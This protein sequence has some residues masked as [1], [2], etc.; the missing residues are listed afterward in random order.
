[1]FVRF[2]VFNGRKLTAADMA[3]ERRA[4]R[5]MALKRRTGSFA[6]VNRKEQV[7]ISH[8]ENF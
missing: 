5:K 7:R 4:Q 6:G 2:G 1:M 8:D 3:A